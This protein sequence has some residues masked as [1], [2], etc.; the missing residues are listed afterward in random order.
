MRA[1]VLAAVL[2]A[3]CAGGQAS[4]RPRPAG[5]PLGE[6]DARALEARGR[7]LARAGD[8]VRA[9]QYLQAALSRGAS[10]ERV[11]PLLLEVCLQASRY[12]AALEHAL[13]QLERH[14]DDWRAR[15]L[16]ASLLHYVVRDPARARLQLERI[17]VQAPDEPLPRWLLGVVLSDGLGERR[18]A[19]VQFRRYLALDP[20]GRHAD[21]ARAALARRMP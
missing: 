10:P 5:D 14:P 17:V 2:A 8:L 7:E 11:T 18:A 12:G 21:D 19:A 9:E 3:A 13:A 16:V 15:L 4:L 6:L 1:L 20:H